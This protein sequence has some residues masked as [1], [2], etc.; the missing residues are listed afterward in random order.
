[1]IVD[2]IECTIGAFVL[3]IIIS[4]VGGKDENE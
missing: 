4:Q 3:A 2:V 1:M